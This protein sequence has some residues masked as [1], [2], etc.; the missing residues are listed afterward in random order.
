[1]G[2]AIEIDGDD[3]RGTFSEMF[4]LEIGKSAPD[5]QQLST[6]RHQVAITSPVSSETLV[7]ETLKYLLESEQFGLGS[8]RLNVR[9][10]K[11]IPH[12]LLI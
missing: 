10:P 6:L 8:V 12:K 3:F 5:V 11:A 4:E 9:W 2:G 1:M 7:P